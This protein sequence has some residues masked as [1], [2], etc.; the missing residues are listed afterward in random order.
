MRVAW[1]TLLQWLSVAGVFLAWS[2]CALLCLG[3]FMLAVFSIS[4]T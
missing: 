3:G 4:G 1:G 2:A